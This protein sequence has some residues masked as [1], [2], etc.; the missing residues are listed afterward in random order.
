MYTEAPGFHP[1]P[2]VRVFQYDVRILR[3]V[4]RSK[5]E[6]YECAALLLGDTDH[7]AVRAGRAPRGSNMYMV[8]ATS[9]TRSC[10]GLRHV[11]HA[12]CTDARPVVMRSVA[13]LTFPFLL[14]PGSG[15]TSSP[16]WAT[17]T[18]CSC[19][20]ATTPTVPTPM[21]P[22]GKACPNVATLFAH[23]VPVYLY[24]L[25]AATSLARPIVPFSAQV[26]PLCL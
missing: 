4:S 26:E 14:G 19:A 17:C 9:F 23:I 8:L 15:A 24:I 5:P 11:I 12:Q 25:A 21:G 1:G 6:V 13:A 22:S 10:T 2:G 7:A 18:P 16:A 3:Q 20:A